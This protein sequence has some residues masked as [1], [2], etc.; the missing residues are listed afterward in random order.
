M[1]TFFAIIVVLASLAVVAWP[2]LKGGR[3]ELATEALVDSEV[4]ELLAQRDATLFAISE[5]ESDKEMGN[6]S[7]ADYLDLRR[8]YEE[9]AVA[10]I[11]AADGLKEERGLSIPYSPDGDQDIE[12]EIARIRRPHTSG[13]AGQPRFCSGCGSELAADAAF[14]SRCGRSTGAV[15]PQCAA[16]V[17]TSDRFCAICGATLGTEESQ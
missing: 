8:K 12:E 6:L 15:C 14:C 1:I 3:R 9:K 17:E 13:V 4:N 16:T 2:L 7:Q 11:K 10:L 5:L